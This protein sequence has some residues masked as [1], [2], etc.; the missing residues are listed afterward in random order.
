[1]TAP[2]TPDIEV[3][4][5]RLRRASEIRTAI[6]TEWKDYLDRHPRRFGL[7][8]AED[9]GQ[10]TFVINT[11]EPMPVRISA[12]FGEWLY[13]L[14]AALDGTAYHLAVRDSGQNPP[15][16]ER[17]IYF[18]IKLDP[19]KYDSQGHR[20]NLKALSDTTFADLRIVQPFNAQPDHLSN[21]LWWVEELA[22]IDRHRGG[23]ALAAHIVNVRVGLREPLTLVKNHLPEP[24]IGRVPIDESAPMPILDLQAP[25]DFDEAAV[26]EHMDISNAAENVL[27]VTEWAANATK[28]MASDELHMRM[29][30]C[31]FFLREGIIEPLLTGETQASP[32][33]A[34]S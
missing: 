13:L 16:N 12:L 8:Q 9:D 18:P 25:A 10:W 11:V 2:I 31:E 21:A 24:A 19:A 7:V 1:M 26:R 27:D 22:R 34:T 6:G 5:D 17:N 28:P 29:G 14:R 15:P 33:S 30:M 23:H 32:P 4:R 3:L 20:D